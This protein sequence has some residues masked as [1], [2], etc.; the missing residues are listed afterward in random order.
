M[1]AIK[2]LCD[3]LMDENN[4]ILSIDVV[5][6]KTLVT[7]NADGHTEQIQSPERIIT[8]RAIYGGKK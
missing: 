7:R 2:K 8:I 4:E 3:W 1:D 5:P 6:G